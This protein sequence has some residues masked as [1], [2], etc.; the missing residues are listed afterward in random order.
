MEVIQIVADGMSAGMR[1]EQLARL[2]LAYPT[3]TAIVGLA[4]RRILGEIGTSTSTGQKIA[5]Q[6]GSVEWAWRAM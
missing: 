6:P 5:R 4:A 1:V 3:F 2:E